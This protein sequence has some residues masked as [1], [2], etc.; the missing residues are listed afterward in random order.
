MTDL[1]PSEPSIVTP[2]GTF[3]LADYRVGQG[4][5]EWSVLHAGT[6]LTQAAET[7]AIVLKTNRVPY[8]ISLWPGAIAL[9]HE[10]ADRPGD[11]AGRSVLELGS[12]TGLPGIVA[13]GQGARVVQTDHEE[14]VLDLCCR[15][16]ARNDVRG[17][18]YRLADWTAWTDPERYDWII[19]A[20]VL[21][22]EDLH[23]DL[24]RIFEQNLAPGGRVL[25]ADPFRKMSLRLLDT[26]EA[27]GWRVTSSRWEI[28]D[29][30]PPRPVGVFELAPPL[31]SDPGPDG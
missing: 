21:Y 4:E 19:G 1:T 23:A 11:F 13:A 15:N 31:V 20:D 24:R 10:V 3:P 7:H 27:A 2:G 25:I 9:A 5:R 30:S 26:L 8:G 6:I 12:G 29:V 18:E 14:L 22:V 17:V 28:G 16:G